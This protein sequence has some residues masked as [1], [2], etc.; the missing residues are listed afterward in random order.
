MMYIN[1]PIAIKPKPNTNEIAP[2]KGS[3]LDA[4]IKKPNT[5]N[6]PPPIRKPL[7]T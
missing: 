6:I 2:A 1:A 4:A 5:S 3:E 7:A